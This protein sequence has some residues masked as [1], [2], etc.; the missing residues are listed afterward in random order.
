MAKERIENKVEALA[1]PVAGTLGLEI[2]EVVYQKEAGDWYL[3]IFIDSPAGVNINDCQ[4]FSEAMG[5]VLDT[6]EDLF[7]GSYLLEVSSPGVAR[8]LRKRA[9]F[10]RFAGKKVAIKLAK[11]VAGSRK[12]AGELLG[13]EQVDQE[14]VILI[15]INSDQ[16]IK[17]PKKIVAKANLQ[18]DHF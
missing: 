3:R 11:A 7:P 13:I 10:E 6:Q 14:E 1:E 8:P 18:L 2:V 15:K 16:I 12:Y 5:A 17:L 9:D 4:S